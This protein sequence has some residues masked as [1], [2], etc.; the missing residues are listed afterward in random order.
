MS[1]KTMS[2]LNI[3]NNSYEIKDAF[4][5]QKIEE[6]NNTTTEIKDRID[7]LWDDC[8]T[9]TE[10]VA[11]AVE[12]AAQ[13]KKNADHTYSDM[14]KFLP[15][16]SA[17]GV[18]ASFSD[19]AD[20][21]PL[22]SLV[23]GIEPVQDLHGYENPW[24]VGGGKNLFGLSDFTDAYH[25][26]T[27]EYESLSGKLSTNGTSTAGAGTNV[28]EIT[29]PEG[30]YTFS[31]DFT[32]ASGF[33]QILLRDK[34]TD[35]NVEEIRADRPQRTVTLNGTYYIRI[36][37]QEGSVNSGYI[38]N[39]QLELGESKTN[40]AP[41]SNICPITGWTE[42]NITKT[43]KNLIPDISNMLEQ[44]TIEGSNGVEK[45]ASNRVRTTL[46][47]FPY[48]SIID[49]GYKLTIPSG[50]KLAL[51]FWTS[52][53][54][55]VTAPVVG[56]QTSLR[57][58]YYYGKDIA[59]ARFVYG[60]TDNSDITPSQ[61]SNIGFQLE[62]GSTATDYEPYVSDT[63]SITFPS[64]AGTVYG[65]TLDV[66]NGVLTVDKA[67]VDLGAMTWFYQNISNH[68]RFGGTGIRNT[69]AVPA[70]T[71]V[72]VDAICSRYKVITANQTYNHNA[73]IGISV[74]NSDGTI[75]VYDGAYTDSTAFRTAMSGV[76]FC[77]PLATPITYQLTPT[78]VKSFLGQNNIYTDCGN[79]SVK[80]HADTTTYINRKIAE[81][82]N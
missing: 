67:M 52:S 60:K 41:Y 42:A 79:V 14:L 46:I 66:T 21:I 45:T 63:L 1:N 23:V 53:M 29:V 11:E 59:Y 9:V 34:A 24:P 38:N 3:G 57:P 4:A 81:A 80:Y 19:G 15:T 40:F 33:A 35:T 64:E 78:E 70:S 58:E 30:T 68:E 27:Y 13:A 10:S 8:Q 2:T 72:A 44:G 39:I 49:T 12:M 55:Y 47:P 62:L 5:R 48:D 50:Y 37:A 36:A 51:R 18:I 73:G 28:S 61:V 7:T 65:G 16:D 75:Y 77:Y 71:D 20:D 56:F 43:G 26:V 76:Q 17:S 22:K 54:V 25:G 6:M 69:V 74:S 32:N 31:A 82:I